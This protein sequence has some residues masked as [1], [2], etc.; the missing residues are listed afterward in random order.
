MFD[1]EE[2]HVAPQTTEILTRAE[3][4][5]QLRDSGFR[6]R[7]LANPDRSIGILIFLVSLAYLYLFRRYTMMEPD[8]GIILQG[9]ER[10]LHGQ[11]PYRDFF[12]FYTPGSYYLTAAAL[13]LLGDSLAAA[14]TA[15]AIGASLVSALNYLLARRVCSRGA[16][17]L[18]AALTTSTCLP[19]RDLVLHNW[20][21]TLWAMLALYT[22]VRY[23]E[24]PAARL[25]FALGSLAAVTVLFEQS[26]G[27]GLVLGLG[28]GFTVLAIASCRSSG[29]ALTAGRA[30]APMRPLRLQPGTSVGTPALQHL[31]ALA[32]G[33]VWPLLLVVAWFAHQHALRLM[34][35]DWLWPL[36]HY[37]QAN[38]VR[39][40]YQNWSEASRASLFGASWGSRVLVLLVVTP[41][42]VIPVLPLIAAGVFAWLSYRA[43]HD[44]LDGG[45][46]GG[47]DASR[48][49]GRDIRQDRRR[50]ACTTKYYLLVSAVIT[51]LL[52]SVLAGRADIL[53][54]IYL[55]PMLYLVLAWIFDGR[56]V[57]SPLFRALQPAL[58]VVI[59]VCFFLLAAAMAVTALTARIP[60]QTRRG[61]VRTSVSDQV[62]PVIQ[63]QVSAGSTIF[64]YPYLPLYYYLSGTFASG[65]HD[66]LQP[67]MH[68]P[69]QQAEM[70]RDVTADRTPV[71]LYEYGFDEKIANSWPRT[72]LDAIASD[73]V[74]DFLWAQYQSCSVLKSAAG[75][76]F[77]LMIRKDLPCPAGLPSF[78]P[79]R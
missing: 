69:A 27:A 13:K 79:R 60:I 40:G 46:N 30:G 76:R 41:C 45:L 2:R 48:D 38:S 9:A 51:G 55:A 68:T 12:S 47:Q 43:I 73:P 57:S 53:H 78:Y 6:F 34:L 22:A 31:P 61:E 63:S 49:S 21:S 77:L 4:E 26:K 10:V 15:V 1:I 65:R 5:A 14:R 29:R 64:V 36:H 62:L 42:F 18:A 35:G 25:A 67:G 24:A 7:A 32:A 20:D 16:A 59:M 75:G 11:V 17:L 23:L 56:D 70:I 52:L 39:Y 71:V 33:F 8:E 66:Y 58:R 3:S 54:F 37:S 74:A 19:Y 50:D 72:P 44:G 28:L